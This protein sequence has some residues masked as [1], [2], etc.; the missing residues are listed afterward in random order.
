MND[1]LSKYQTVGEIEDLIA[2]FNNCSL[3]RA[4]WNHAAHLTVALWYFTHEAE[5]QASDRIRQ[6]IQRYN[7]A[8]GIKT[9][10]D[11]GYHETLTLFW[12]EMVRR[13]LA[14]NNR[15]DSLLHL[16]NKLIDSYNNKHLPLQYYSRDL[17]M[18]PE[19]RSRWVEPDLKPL[20]DIQP[21]SI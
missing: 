18:S 9:I 6:S 10:K 11:S 8:I 5:Q 3:S 7:T 1:E 12:I 21:F 20:V 16:T 4:K 17:L 19:A 13:Y 2:A 15:Q 14:V